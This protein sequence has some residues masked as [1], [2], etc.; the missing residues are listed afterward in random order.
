[1]SLSTIVALL[2]AALSFLITAQNNPALTVESRQQAIMFATQ[3]VQIAQQALQSNQ[4]MKV[5]D[6]RVEIP[7][8][9]NNFLET[10]STDEV[11]IPEIETDL[12]VVSSDGKIFDRGYQLEAK[13]ES[14]VIKTLVIAVGSKADR[15]LV[16]PNNGALLVSQSKGIVHHFKVLECQNV[17]PEFV[18]PGKEINTPEEY[19][20]AGEL[21]YVSTNEYTIAKDSLYRLEIPETG[22]LIY[23]KAV[24][25]LTGNV[26]E[27]TF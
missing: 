24:G 27:K 20:S 2:Q 7:S 3:S 12:S 1:M 15:E 6:A 11:A 9:P 26:V 19:Q 8:L 25:E 22:R 5:E 14:L 4:V 10:G 17:K 18:C 21:G 13:G 23:L 16:Y